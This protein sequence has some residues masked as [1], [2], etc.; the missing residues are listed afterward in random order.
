MQFLFKK[1]ASAL[2]A[3][4]SVPPRLALC[5]PIIAFFLKVMLSAAEPD[6]PTPPVE[7]RHE[8]YYSATGP[9]GRLQCYDFY[10]EAPENLTSLFRLPSS[11][12]RWTFP[13]SML[14]QLPSVLAKAGLDEEDR[15]SVV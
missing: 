12:T 9:W 7:K 14:S 15:K 3:P 4:T 8:P 6:L 1:Q 11:V 10:L 2:N 13:R 5:A